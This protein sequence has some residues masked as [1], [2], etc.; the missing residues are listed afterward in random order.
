[1]DE[2]HLIT[3][4]TLTLEE[5]NQ[6]ISKKKKLR[7]SPL[8][9]RLILDCRKYL[10]EKMEI[11]QNLYYGINTGF[12]AL[13]N[14][15]ISEKEI[16]NLQENL[17]L[18]HA[19]G[20]GEEVPKEVVKLMLL[21]KIHALALGHSGITFTLEER[22]I[23]FFNKD[24]TPVVFQQ[25]SLGAS[26]DLAPLAH[27]SLPLIGKGE[28]FFHGKRQKATT[29]LKKNNLKPIR[30]QAKEG[31][32]LLNGTQFMTAYGVW[33]LII[34]SRLISWGEKTAALSIDAFNVKTDSLL[35]YTH[36][37]RPHTGQIT[38]AKNILNFLKGS[39]ISKT[40][41]TQV[42]D[43]YSFRCIPQVQGA[44]RDTFDFAKKVVETEINSVTDNPILFPE[45]DLILS[46]GN[47]HG[48]PLALAFDY[49][50]IAMAEL[51]SISERR[52]YL[53][54]SGQRG[55]PP[56]LTKE[57]GLNSGLMIAQYT[58][59]SIVSQNKQLCTPASVDSIT[60]SNGQ[61]DHVS[62]GANAAT[63]LWKVVNNVE[64]ILAIEFLCAAQAIEFRRPLKTSVFLEEEIK[65]FREIIPIRNHDREIY[66]DIE[67]SRK[68]L[69]GT[70]V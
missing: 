25:G 56:F 47:F 63:K 68:F 7:L 58:A 53:L 35:P 59:A 26:G 3:R 60:S 30:L 49:L 10:N 22:L 8:S 50:A 12:G 61:E 4:R 52:I 29:V 5:V 36:R 9:K 42:Q 16:Q 69:E 40:G 31:L 43:P 2:I 6:I 15:R 38:T 48:Q 20:T 65:K 51:G 64:T 32:A 67:K 37:V 66:P 33:C 14:V 62:M 39:K 41:K 57:A 23:D 45:E 54:L 18:S 11:T 27:L 17:V 13:C 46:G 1:M 28:V 70:T 21:L 34:S 44:T 55:L 24:I 19:A